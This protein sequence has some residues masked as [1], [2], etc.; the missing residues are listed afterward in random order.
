MLPKNS[1]SKCRND[2]CKWRTRC[3]K[4]WTI[5]SSRGRGEP[6]LWTLK[7][8]EWY[9]AAIHR[10]RTWS[11]TSMRSLPKS[12]SS[13]GVRC[14]VGTR[15]RRERLKVYDCRWG[16]ACCLSNQD[17]VSVEWR[18]LSFWSPTGS[19]LRTCSC[20]TSFLRQ[21]QLPWRSG[22]THKFS[23][24]LTMKS[25]TIWG[26]SWPISCTAK[27]AGFLCESRSA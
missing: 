26:K 4:R 27:M 3:G 18:A 2:G 24:R 10:R 23:I 7:F 6:V 9:K 13:A 17:C 15:R 22:L 16:N 11:T 25:G 8:G 21:R 5:T 19:P 1:W 12:Q 20:C 14:W